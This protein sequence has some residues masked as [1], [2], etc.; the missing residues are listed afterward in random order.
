MCRIVTVYLIT[1][2]EKTCATSQKNI[3]SHVFWILKKRKKTLKSNRFMQPLITRLPEVGTG[4]S[5]S[6][7]SNILLRS[8]D[9]R[10]Y[11]TENCVW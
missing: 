6:R 8:V 5:R 3:K 2:F 1:V 4:K 10:K 9:T 11:A 7:T